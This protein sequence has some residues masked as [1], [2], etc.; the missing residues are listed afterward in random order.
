MT[1][2]RTRRILVALQETN[3][4]IDKEEKRDPNL[5]PKEIVERLAFYKQHRTKL[6]NMLNGN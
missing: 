6:L 5:R 2:E 3:D 1:D 4:Y